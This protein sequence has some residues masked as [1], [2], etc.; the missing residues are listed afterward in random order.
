MMGPGAPF[1]VA[2]EEI[3]GQFGHGAASHRPILFG[4]VAA[5]SFVPTGT[6]KNKLWCLHVIHFEM[7]LLG[8]S[9]VPR[10][11]QVLAPAKIEWQ[12][13]QN[14]ALLR[15]VLFGTVA[16]SSL[17]PTGTRKNKLWCLHVLH[18]V[19]RPLGTSDGPRSFQVA[20]SKIEWQLRQNDALL[21]HILFGTVAASSLSPTGTR[22]NKLRCLHVLHFEVRPLWWHLMCPGACKWH[23]GKLNGNGAITQLCYVLSC[24]ERL[25]HHL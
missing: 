13:R 19:V 21:R 12:L 15:P 20:P 7:Q 18:F 16:A 25:Q 4:T 22:K 8:T 3:D 23:D 9:N 24:L 1:Q 11:F 17:V 6:R 5:S 10:S 2:P 14:E